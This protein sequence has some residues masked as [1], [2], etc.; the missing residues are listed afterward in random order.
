MNLDIER[1][2]VCGLAILLVG[3]H[4]SGYLSTSI[5]LKAAA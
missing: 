5:E 4:K 2:E 3:A 1:V